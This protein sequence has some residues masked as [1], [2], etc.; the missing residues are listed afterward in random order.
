MSPIYLPELSVASGDGGDPTEYVPGSGLALKHGGEAVMLYNG[1]RIH[2]QAVLD[3]YWV[4]SIDGLFSAEI[5]T[6]SDN[7]PGDHGMTPHESFFGAKTITIEGEI[8]SGSI[9]KIRDMQQG[10]TQVFNDLGDKPLLFLTG[11][12]NNDFYVMARPSA[13][14]RMVEKQDGWRYTRPYLITLT[15]N[16]GRILSFIENTITHSIS[17]NTVAQFSCQNKGNFPAR[18]IITLTGNMTDPT[19][20]NTTNDYQLS[21]IGNIPTGQSI[22]V[23]YGLGRKTMKWSDGS[24]AWDMM[25]LS[26][27]RKFEI[28]R[29]STDIIEASA[30]GVGSGAAVTV[31][32]RSTW[33]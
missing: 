1:L 31:N 3:T 13:A 7:H 24:S 20:I 23:E 5:R 29:A 16:D 18:P 30:P 14:L 15:A 21:L 8:R 4:S 33:W 6:A 9:S 28:N 10:L 2:D 26:S 27:T 32:W 19:I 11:D 25:G 22:T 12:Q 17:S